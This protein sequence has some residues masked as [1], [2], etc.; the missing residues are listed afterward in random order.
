MHRIEKTTHLIKRINQYKKDQVKDYELITDICD[1][2]DFIKGE[3]DISQADYK[4]L[5]YIAN[6]V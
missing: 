3:P 6:L 1:F 5:R 2:F 4:F